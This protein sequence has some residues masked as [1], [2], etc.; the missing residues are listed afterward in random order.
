MFLSDTS[1]SVWE[2]VCQFTKSR[3]F[4]I[5]ISVDKR[6]SPTLLVTDSHIII[7]DRNS[8]PTPFASLLQW[9]KSIEKHYE[10]EK[11]RH[12]K[13]LNSLHRCSMYLWLSWEC[14][15]IVHL[16]SHCVMSNYFLGSN[17]FSCLLRLCPQLSDDLILTFRDQ[18]TV[19]REKTF[20]EQKKRTRSW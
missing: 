15:F 18:W 16:L 7:F 17:L 9:F 5:C 12:C 19:E 1:E 8:F 2:K 4:T 6:V 13:E 10:S 14:I 3:G 20:S 11:F